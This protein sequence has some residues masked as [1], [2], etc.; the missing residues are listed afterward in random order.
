MTGSKQPMILQQGRLLITKTL[1]DIL[2]LL[3]RQHH[4]VEAVVYN[5]IVVERTRV[6]RQRVDLPAQ[7]TPCPPVD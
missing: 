3:L 7:G 6:F 2:A 1:R 5:D 4:A